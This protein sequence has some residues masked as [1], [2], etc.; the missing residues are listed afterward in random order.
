MRVHLVGSNTWR[1][2]TYDGWHRE[3][4][5][6]T[7]FQWT[8]Q[9]S[10]RLHFQAEDLC[11]AAGQLLILPQDIGNH[12]WQTIGDQPWVVHWFAARLEPD[13]QH[14]LAYPVQPSGARLLPAP[15]AL[16][17]RL[18]PFL[19]R[20]LEL[21]GQH[22]ATSRALRD[23]L[24][25]SAALEIRTFHGP[26]TAPHDAA[27]AQALAVI[28]RRLDDPDLGLRDLV[29]AAGCSRSVLVERFR[30]SLG[31]SPMQ[32]VEWRRLRLAADYLQHSQA[33]VTSVA[34]AVGFRSPQYFATRFRRQ[35]GCSPRDYRGSG[36]IET[37]S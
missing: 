26:P 2:A 5:S 7:I 35:F 25:R 36:P 24:G 32:H 22:D 12:R 4:P 31:R 3:L 30:H 28:D 21:R 16:I 10:M 23:A 9:G 27:L 29:N 14:L 18:S 34:N 17:Q 1:D 33:S 20:M 15:D 8:T 37:E 19:Q 13:E 11:I 6:Y